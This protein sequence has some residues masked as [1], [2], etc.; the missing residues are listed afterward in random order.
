MALAGKKKALESVDLS[1]K[2]DFLRIPNQKNR[3]RKL[4]NLLPSNVKQLDAY[5]V[6]RFA[7]SS[8]GKATKEL[9]YNKL[10]EFLDG[11]SNYFEGNLDFEYLRT[12]YIM[13]HYYTKIKSSENSVAR[14]YDLTVPGAHTFTANGF[15]CH[16]SGKD[17]SKVDR[18]GA[19]A[20][21]YVA[22]NVVAAGLADKCEVQLSYA[23]GVAQPTSIN[24]DTFGTNKIAEAKIQELVKKHFKLTPTWIIDHLKL[25][26]P[27]YRKTA[28]YGHFGR[29]DPDFTWEKTDMAETLRQ[30]A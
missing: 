27:I 1:S 5:K 13:N 3:I 24:V 26:R 9:T 28:A 30:E 25:R 4:W 23:I 20:A 17:P 2:V 6:G 7:R 22:K 21:R 10:K 29:N 18:S 15:V 19:Y 11:Y 8:K 12:F 16:N 14:V